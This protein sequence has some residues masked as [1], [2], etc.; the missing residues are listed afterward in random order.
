MISAELSRLGQS[1]SLFA[2]SSIV[3]LRRQQD[4]SHVVQEHV[5]RCAVIHAQRCGHTVTKLL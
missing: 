1:A 2:H 3:A 4:R 5:D